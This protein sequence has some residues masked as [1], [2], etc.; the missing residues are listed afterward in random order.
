MSLPK[1]VSVTIQNIIIVVC[2]YFAGYYFTASFHVLSAMIGGLWAVISAI[3]VLES[4]FKETLHSAK[5]RILGSLI[6]AIIAGVYLL[7]FPFTVVGFA[8]CIGVG[9]FANHLI[10]LPYTIKLTG[11]TIAV[12]M[13]VSAL[14]DNLH[15]I[16]NAI[17]RFVES[18]I[19][20]VIAAIVSY[21]SFYIGKKNY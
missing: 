20:S 21:I 17:L 16:Y 3:I 13:I 11:V 15:P 5:V 6:G 12:V 10:G 14:S 9:A 4:T 19:G 2:A 18:A 7:F 1:A 8:I